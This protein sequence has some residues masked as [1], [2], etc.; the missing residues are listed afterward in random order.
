MK[1]YTVHCEYGATGEG[2]TH[3]IW[4]G[5]CEDDAEAIKQFTRHFDPYYA[6]GAEVVSGFCFEN[7]SAQ[8]LVS[9]VSKQFLT[10]PECYKSY[11]AQ[12]HVNYS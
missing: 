8:L 4:M 11:H 3:M 2:I 5:F 1:A 12:L 9:D 7:A 10:D 6:Q